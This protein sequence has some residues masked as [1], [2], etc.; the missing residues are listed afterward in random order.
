MLSEQSR[1]RIAAALIWV[2]PALWATNYIVARSAAGVIEPYTLA[3]GRWVLVGS[4]LV[5][6][7]RVELWQHRVHLASSWFHYLALGALGMFVCGAWVY[8]GA[9]TTVTMNMALIYSASPVLIALG[10]VVWLNERFSW[11]QAG[12]VLLALSGVMHV[13]VRGQWL[14]LT[15][16]QWVAGDGWILAAMVSWAAFALLQK[17]W[18]SPLG[19]S[20]R[21]A[22]ICVGGVVLLLPLAGRE[23]L[24]GLAPTW[25]PK[26]T[27]LVLVAALLPGLGAY[28]L[29]SWAQKVIGASRVAVTLYL[30][31]LYAALAAWLLL[32]EPLGWHH[33]MGAGMILPGVYLVNQVVRPPDP[34]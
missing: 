5:F 2:I 12:G 10:A 15:Q 24:S 3:F 27:T 25:T 11:R 1:L 19:E 30:A 26:A 23:M 9:K 21:L 18:H 22:M 6:L 34:S 17:R 29:Y 32:G 4:L 33:L 31:P 13:I 7:T 28:W 8:Q 14:A 20:A 16:V